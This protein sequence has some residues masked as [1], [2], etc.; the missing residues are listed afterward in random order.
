MA[1]F[2]LVE[3]SGHIARNCNG[4]LNGDI[5][6]PSRFG[7]WLLAKSPNPH[8]YQRTLHLQSHFNKTQVPNASVLSLLLDLP[9]D[10]VNMNWRTTFVYGW[11]ATRDRNA[12]WED[13]KLLLS[14]YPEPWVCIGDFNAISSPYEK[15]GGDVGRPS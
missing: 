15:I 3:S 9:S 4:K 7:L 13:M 2:S 8:P 5:A 1:S 11:P 14:P 10:Q 12:F 6:P